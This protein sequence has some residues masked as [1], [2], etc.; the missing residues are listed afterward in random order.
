MRAGK[1][2]GLAAMFAVAV[3]WL[4]SGATRAE[5]LARDSDDLNCMHGSVDDPRTVEA[6]SRLR[7]AP[8]TADEIAAWREQGF[9]RAND[10][11]VCHHG[12]KGAWR[13]RLAC[14]HLRGE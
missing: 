1:I 14:Q 11:Y 5:G 10:D 9:Q 7:G 2:A 13:T 3:M 12:R 4:G 8:V 6:C